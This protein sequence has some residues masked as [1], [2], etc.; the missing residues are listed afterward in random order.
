MALRY[1]HVEAKFDVRGDAAG[2]IFDPA[3]CVT[4]AGV[5]RYSDGKGGWR[6][7]YRPPREVFRRD[8]LETLKILPV[9]NTHEG[10]LVTP[11]N[12]KARRIGSTGSDYH[13]DGLLVLQEVKID[14]AGGIDA[15]ERGRKQLSLGY[16]CDVLEESGTTDEGEHYDAIQTNIRYNHLAIEDKARAGDVA[17]LH[18][19]A[20]DR[21]QIDETTSKHLRFDGVSMLPH[22][23]T[24]I[25]LDSLDGKVVPSPTAIAAGVAK[26][27][28]DEYEVDAWV[29]FYIEDLRISFNGSQAR[30]DA[31]EEL[32]RSAQTLTVTQRARADKAEGERDSL[33][34]K[35]DAYEGAEAKTKF[36]A[37]VNERIELVIAA[38][39]KLEAETV[40]KLDG[41]SNDEIRVACIKVSVPT[42]DATGKESAYILAR[43]DG[44]ADI[45]ARSAAEGQ[46][47]QIRGDGSGTS[48]T[49]ADVRF[50]VGELQ[51]KARQDNRDK[52][53]GTAPAK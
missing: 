52:Y 21:V 10:G 44:L 20:E 23:K 28:A 8:S 32:T 6:Y 37:A 48:R 30:A 9:V 15:V 22:L 5:F 19:D 25:K 35:L 11:E 39:E 53:F 33:K 17:S 49:D 51:R 50:D 14:E 1:D 43:Y 40:A 36:D 31:A 3:A 26:Y 27:D 29:Q 7:E 24:K 45:G 4:R 46:L 34:T 41:M 12:V 18:L 13:V 47:K 16:T 42:F 2:V 38:R